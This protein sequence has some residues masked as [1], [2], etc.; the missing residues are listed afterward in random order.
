MP[1]HL[2]TSLILV[3]AAISAVHGPGAAAMSAYQWKKRPLLVFAPA[4]TS[5]DL[6]RQRGIVAQYGPAF[7]DRHMVVVYVI[8]DT[9]TAELGP[10]PGMTAAALRAR[11]GVATGAFRAVLVGKDGGTKLSSQGPLA[12]AT[13]FSTIDAMPMRKNEMKRGS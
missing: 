6:Q 5:P 12:A 1:K 4:A 8:G 7:Q 13:L 3:G 10:G 2:V 11:Y 9:V